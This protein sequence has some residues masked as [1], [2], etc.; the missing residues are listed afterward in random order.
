M[1]EAKKNFGM[2]LN[3]KNIDIESGVK[4]AKSLD[5]DTI[6]LYALH[7]RLNLA[8]KTKTRQ[9][10]LKNYFSNSGIKIVSLAIS[11]GPKGILNVPEDILITQFKQI[12]E[13]GLILGSTII[14]AHIGEIP[15]KENSREY[16]KLLTICNKLGSISM[17][18]DSI[19]AIETGS[20]RACVLETFLQKINSK[21]L[22]INFDPANIMMGTSENPLQSL[23]ILKEYIVQTHIKDCKKIDN[24]QTRLFKEMSAGKG[25]LDF[26]S[27]FSILEQ[28]NY[29]G[30]HI[31]ENSDYFDTSN[32]IRQSVDFLKKMIN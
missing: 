2:F 1:T 29:K 17:L 12:S 5:I 13:L 21:G 11:F 4:L 28:S 27:I 7:E 18:S 20:E 19:F 16:E 32:G 26:K 25:D 3:T 23:N 14:S 24:N 10:Q 31:I 15:L 22:G 6:Q 30:F 9:Y 8:C